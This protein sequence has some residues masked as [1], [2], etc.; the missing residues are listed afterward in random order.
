[1]NRK[2]KS[3]LI[4]NGIKQADIAKK[5]G[6]SR[7]TV[8]GAINGHHQSRPVKQAVADMLKMDYDKLCKIWGK[9]A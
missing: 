6:Y 7:G 2:I 3:L 5:L 1:M 9:A 8:S 4:K